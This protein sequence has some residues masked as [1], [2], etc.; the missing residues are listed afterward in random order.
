[1]TSAASSSVTTEAA[2]ACGS[3]GG[4]PGLAHVTDAASP[5]PPPPLIRAV[6]AASE[7]HGQRCKR[8][9]QLGRPQKGKRPPALVRVE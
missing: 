6:N 2:A 9:P 1:M 5:P 7:A 4:D 3:C 8:L